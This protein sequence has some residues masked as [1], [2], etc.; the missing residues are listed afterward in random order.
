MTA[1]EPTTTIEYAIR[2]TERSAFNGK[3]YTAI[4]PLGSGPGSAPAQAA[5]DRAVRVREYQAAEGLPVDAVA[6]VCTV[7]VTPWQEVSR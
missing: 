5:L 7:T 2:Y 4:K 1:Q 6:V 3:P